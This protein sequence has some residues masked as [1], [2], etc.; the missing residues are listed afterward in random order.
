[1]SKKKV[2]DSE[3][4]FLSTM[5]KSR[6]AKMPG[7]DKLGRIL[8][9]ADYAE[10][11]RL[12]GE[13]G[14]PDLSGLDAE[15]L[16]AALASFRSETL[17]EIEKAVPEKCIVEA[18]RLKYDYHN[19]KVMVKSRAA[20]V[21]GEKLLSDSGRVSKAK[22]MAAFNDDDTA[23]LPEKFAQAMEKAESIMA[24]TSNPQLV[25][26]NLDRSYFEELLEVA[27]QE[28]SGFLLRYA[29]VLIDSANLRTFVRVTRMG[30]DA[31]FLRSTLI[32]GGNVGVEE[33]VAAS[34]SGG[35]IAQLFGSTVFE[36]AAKAGE[37]AQK[38]G[39]LTEFE[40]ACDNA[41]TA[42][43]ESVKLRSFGAETVIAY[44]AALDQELT[45]IRMILTGKLSGAEP[46]TIRERLR[47]TYA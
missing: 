23:D 40:L 4:L 29:K 34:L 33:L 32:P 10:S 3:Y 37:Q 45:S 2:R 42:F 30:K 19:A 7:K 38:E 39:S 5:L 35:S 44:I 8:D 41:V 18:F 13:C 43:I 31:E 24:R 26:I 47:D 28:S 6:E 12:A 36:N 25:D 9:A 22:L 20:N 21:D 46:D 14:Y 17:G 11:A 1:M 15:G 27:G 16:N